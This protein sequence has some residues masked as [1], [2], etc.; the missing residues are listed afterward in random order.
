LIPYGLLAMSLV[1]S[2]IANS[3]RRNHLCPQAFRTHI[4]KGDEADKQVDQKQRQA[5][6]EFSQRQR[7]DRARQE[8]GLRDAVPFAGNAM[9]VATSDAPRPAVADP[10]FIQMAITEDEW[11]SIVL[12]RKPWIWTALGRINVDVPIPLEQAVYDEGKGRVGE[13]AR[14]KAEQ[15]AFDMCERSADNEDPEYWSSEESEHDDN[16]NE[17]ADAKSADAERA[18]LA[19]CAENPDF[20]DV[21]LRLL[22]HYCH[23]LNMRSDL[24]LHVQ[25]V[26][27][28]FKSAMEEATAYNAPMDIGHLQAALGR[29]ADVA[30]P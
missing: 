10:K 20:Q 15:D 22:K 29:Q 25:G 21:A 8:A 19:R 26:C 1:R 28:V 14:R 9:N 16:D 18:F 24:P 23:M 27:D 30:Y 2:S 17:E 6:E 5:W 4:A 3:K 13:Q 7:R 12:K 11:Q